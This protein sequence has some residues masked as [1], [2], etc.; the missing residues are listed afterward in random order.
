MPNTGDPKLDSL[1]V[2]LENSV[3][4]VNAATSAIDKYVLPGP[5]PPPTT[6][7]LPNLWP[8]DT[9]SPWNA[10]LTSAAT[11]G[12]SLGIGNANVNCHWFSIPIYRATSTDPN[13]TIK[14]NSSGQP[15]VC[16]MP[17]GAQPSL[18]TD[19]H[20]YLIQP[21]G[22]TAFGMWNFDPI[23]MTCGVHQVDNLKGSGVNVGWFRATVVGGFGGVI[24][25]EN[26]ANKSIPKALGVCLTP[27]LA[28]NFWQYP[29]FGK[30]GSQTPGQGPNTGNINYGACLALLPSY[31]ASS[32]TPE[33][34]AL[35]ASAKNYGIYVTDT[36]GANALYAECAIEPDPNNPPQGLKNLRTD[37]PKIAANLHVV[38]NATNGNS[39]GP[40]KLNGTPLAPP[41]PPFA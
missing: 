28:S 11:Y 22:V 33:G 30:D 9:S 2:S 29:A 10:P 24:T 16:R 19:R 31:D 26:L 21:D 7:R 32:L 34:Q 14:D 4:G 35:A 25:K 27:N 37:W 36:G 17:A 3:Q 8:Y 15:F 40:A 23:G 39:L 41:A 18:G 20:I 5:T 38:T 6:T 1:I 13:V 12:P